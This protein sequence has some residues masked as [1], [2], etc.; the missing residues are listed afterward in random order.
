MELLNDN[1]SVT[2][3][4]NYITDTLSGDPAQNPYLDSIISARNDDLRN[5]MQASLG[6]RGLTGG[7][8]SADIISQNPAKQ[9]DELRYTAWAN[10]MNRRAE[11]AGMAPGV[12]AGS[13]A[14]A[15]AALGTAGT[16]PSQ[17][18]TSYA[19]GT[20]GLLSPY[21][22]QTQTQSGGFGQLLGGL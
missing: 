14:P 1:P 12:A 11:A 21:G 18:A 7:S 10:E 3:A 15:R 13:I 4:Q 9:D 16:L 17:L 20:G 22:T 8:A 5:Q 6:T 19:A 2:A